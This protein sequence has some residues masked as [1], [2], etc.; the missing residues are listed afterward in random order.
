MIQFDKPTKKYNMRKWKRNSK[1][2]T[3]ADE[4]KQTSSAC[5]V[6][7]EENTLRKYEKG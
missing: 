1:T 3:F 6:K 2:T 4:D 7:V 5:D